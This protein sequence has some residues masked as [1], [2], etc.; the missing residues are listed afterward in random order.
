MFSLFI[1][2]LLISALV[3]DNYSSSNMLVCMSLVW[4]LF[5]HTTIIRSPV[6]LH[7]IMHTIGISNDSTNSMN[8]LLSMN[9]RITYKYRIQ[10]LY[11]EE[12]HNDKR[13]GYTIVGGSFQI[14]FPLSVCDSLSVE[15]QC[16]V[17]TLFSCTWS[18]S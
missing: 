5:D 18:V 7:T 3:C 15:Y 2:L 10:L 4:C 9:L 12:V 16:G 6:T 1:Q 11:I 8:L 13:N 14:Y 17:S